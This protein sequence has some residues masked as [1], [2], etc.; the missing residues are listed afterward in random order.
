MAIEVTAGQIALLSGLINSHGPFAGQIDHLISLVHL[1]SHKSLG[2]LH[3]KI[4]NHTM[5]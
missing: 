1:S 2:A 5:N 3:N 4:E